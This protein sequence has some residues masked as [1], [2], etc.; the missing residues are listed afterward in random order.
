MNT[1]TLAANILLIEEKAYGSGTCPNGEILSLANNLPKNTN[2]FARLYQTI[3][4]SLRN[5]FAS[6]DYHAI[7]AGPLPDRLYCAVP[8][9]IDSEVISGTT[10][11]TTVAYIKPQKILNAKTNY[12]VVVK[13][14]AN[15][16]SN[17]GVVSDEKIG[18][19]ARTFSPLANVEFNGTSFQ[20]SYAFGFTTMDDTSGKN[21]LCTVSSVA[22]NPSS[23]LIKNSENDPG[24][25]DPARPSF[26]TISD[27]DRAVS[28]FAY[29]SDKQLLQPM[30]GYFWNWNFA[31][32]DSSVAKI[33]NI[34][35]L[36][37]N[38]I[39]VAAQSGISDKSTKI[40]ATVNMNNFSSASNCLSGSACTC[41]GDNCSN[42]CCNAS[43]D[44][45]GTNGLS[46]LY[47]FICSNPWPTEKNG[48]WQPWGDNT[49]NCKDALGNTVKC[50]NYNYKFYYCRDSGTPGVPD[51][52]AVMD[53]ALIL[54]SSDLI[55]SVGG[56]PC[57]TQN[58]ACGVG[59]TCIWNVL[60]ESYFFR[61]SIPLSGEITEIKSTGVGGQVEVKW[62]APLNNVLPLASFKL[63]YG[64]ATSGQ[65]SFIKPLSLAEANC[66]EPSPKDGKTY[67]SYKI[68]NLTDNK[69]YYFKVSSVS[70]K[71][72]ESPLSGTIN[73][74]PT[75]TTAPNKPA[76]LKVEQVSG[77]LKLNWD[78]NSDD[79]LYYEVNHG[80][81][82]GKV[83]EK[84]D[85][86]NYSNSLELSLDNYRVG[87][88]FFSVSAIDKS[89]NISLPSDEVKITVTAAAPAN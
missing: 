61:E 82:A 36:R 67:C 46:N 51:L 33:S 70:D 48:I 2:I 89:G 62:Y 17:S 81:F 32:E 13:G 50:L 57:T 63:Y 24:D 12:F 69:E 8:A 45:D 79:T 38:S 66:Q 5:I 87:D 10:A 72:T 20:N 1:P 54:G 52:P 74:T 31:I 27:N 3:S 78:A 53:P 23:F 71:K 44:G 68:S 85:T 60:K 47:V 18:M 58:S 7:A 39:V 37:A 25:D 30:T 65:S 41:S 9:V 84:I 22:V 26:D 42:K 43:F 19:N 83:A 88:H 73:A 55:C 14:D 49:D 56:A 76:G 28:A 86:S 29:S 15:L 4:S 64:L 80:L 6:S 16:D 34:S 75:D 40:T 21:G 11:T 59:G 35:G 77:Q